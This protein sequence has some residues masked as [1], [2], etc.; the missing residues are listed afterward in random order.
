[1]GKI[2][3]S[4]NV[5]LDGVMQDPRGEE[6][7]GRGDWFTV[8]GDRDRQEWAMTLAAEL[9]AADALLLGRRSYEYFAARFPARRDPV[10]DRLN[11]MPKYVLSTTLENPPWPNTTV[12]GGDVQTVVAKLKDEVDGEIVVYASGGLVPA[13]I[14]L[15]LVDELRLMIYPVVLGA[16]RRLFGETSS[17]KPLRL[18]GTRT[19]GEALTLLTYRPRGR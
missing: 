3:V 6:G 7:T 5:S 18:V 13:L 1:M 15:E 12:L 4:E 11:S 2:V 19:V 10:A 17:A 8:I 9:V 14:D 16:G